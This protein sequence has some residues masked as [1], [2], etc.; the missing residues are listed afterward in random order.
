M[1]DNVSNVT[2]EELNIAHSIDS[3][4]YSPWVERVGIYVDN[5]STG[6]III[7]NNINIS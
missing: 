7:N 1:I 6:V 4:K 2:I 5:N 3:Q